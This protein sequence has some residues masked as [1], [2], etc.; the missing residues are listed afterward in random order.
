MMFSPV[1]DKL[2]VMT[3]VFQ[4][5]TYFSQPP[6]LPPTALSIKK[7]TPRSRPAPPPPQKPVASKEEPIDLAD[8]NVACILS[9]IDNSGKEKEEGKEGYNPFLDDSEDTEMDSTPVSTD[10]SANTLSDASEIVEK[11][12]VMDSS[13]SSSKSKNSAKESTSKEG[14][15]DEKKVMKPPPKP[16]RL[17]QTTEISSVDTKTKT[18]VSLD[19]KDKSESKAYNPFDEDDTEELELNKKGASPSK[20]RKPPDG[21]NPFDED[22]GDADSGAQTVN[23]KETKAG[24]NPFDDDDAEGLTQTKKVADQDTGKKD[25]RKKK[26]SY[27]HS[28]NPFEDEGD[29]DS[30]KND[31]EAESKDS[32]NDKVSSS[33][34]Y[35]PFDDDIDDEEGVNN[36]ASE[37]KSATRK[38]SLENQGKVGQISETGRASPGLAKQAVSL[39]VNLAARTFLSLSME[40]V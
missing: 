18:I 39:H 34:R 12:T 37:L 23:D 11:E 29:L 35:N 26:I 33:K 22:E 30:N 21:Y 31:N 36:D 2:A 38:T 17:Y 20:L 13:N 16:P 15:V 8:V 19:T 10:P 32:K 1:P 14:E 9:D 27:P 40:H 24:Y 28:F 6:V 3:Y 4:I 7:P 5:K 25:I